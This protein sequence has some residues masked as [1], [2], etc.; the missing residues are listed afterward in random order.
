MTAMCESGGLAEIAANFVLPAGPGPY[1]D[2]QIHR[3]IVAVGPCQ[4]L[5]RA[6]G[7]DQTRVEPVQHLPADAEPVHDPG[8]EIAPATL[9]MAK[10][11]ADV[12]LAKKPAL[13]ANRLLCRNPHFHLGNAVNQVGISPL[14]SLHHLDRREP[15]QDLLPL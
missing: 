6:G 5:T 11:G 10:A 8:R 9:L 1:L 3:Q 12:I 13:G 15:F 14:W 7:V 4:A 2:R